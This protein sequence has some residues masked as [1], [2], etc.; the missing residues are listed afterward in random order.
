MKSRLAVLVPTICLV[1]A[2]SLGAQRSPDLSLVE[3]PQGTPPEQAAQPDA[4]RPPGPPPNVSALMLEVIISRYQGDKLLSRVP[5]T[6][7]VIPDATGR[8]RLR[9][10]G[11]VAIPS[12][13]RPAADSTDKAPPAGYSYRSIGTNID[14]VAAPAPEGRYRIGITVEES[15]VY[16]PNEAAKSNMLVAG[17]PAFRSLRSENSVVLRDGQ[18]IEY[19]AATDRISGEVARISV[20]LTVVD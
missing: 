8:A 13:P 18:S 14:V 3:A 4:K 20:K 15:S 6:L 7:A 9:V 11:D 5:Y 10:G 17:A 2:A 19:V 16:P 1:L 12:A